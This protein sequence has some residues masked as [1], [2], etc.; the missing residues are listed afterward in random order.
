MIKHIWNIAIIS[1]LLLSC[2]TDTGRNGL[3][4]PIGLTDQW[5]VSDENHEQNVDTNKVSIND[6]DFQLL[7]SNGRYYCSIYFTYDYINFL[8][9]L[10]NNKELVEMYKY[11]FCGKGYVAKMLI[12]EA[13][14]QCFLINGI[15]NKPNKLSIN[16]AL[17]LNDI[18]QSCFN[19]SAYIDAFYEFKD[20]NLDSKFDYLNYEEL[21]SIF[22]VDSLGTS[23]L[24]PCSIN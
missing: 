21:S 16:D 15:K 22:V 12:N 3:E 2:S 20:V 1:T 17:K 9:I 6:K 13:S 14:N 18:L 24:I 7:Y 23:L 10:D 19:S 4:N 8:L 11:S 5:E